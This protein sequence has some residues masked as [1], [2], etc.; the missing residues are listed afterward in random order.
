MLL[1]RDVAQHVADNFAEIDNRDVENLLERLGLFNWVSDVVDDQMIDA[2]K[3]ELPLEPVT[4]FDIGESGV[5]DDDGLE[6]EVEPFLV[7]GGCLCF[8]RAEYGD[9]LG[10]TTMHDGAGHGRRAIERFVT[11]ESFERSGTQ[12]HT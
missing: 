2:G 3:A 10:A 4:K 8:V 7:D 11:T 5:N 1:W 9:T 6:S 12:Q